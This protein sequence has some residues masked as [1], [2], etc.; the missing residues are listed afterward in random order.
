MVFVNIVWVREYLCFEM[1]YKEKDKGKMATTK[2]DNLTANESTS[3]KEVG[4][5][6]STGTAVLSTAT[7]DTTTHEATGNV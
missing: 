2:V 4:V 3:H 5:Q 1:K 7:S 6:D